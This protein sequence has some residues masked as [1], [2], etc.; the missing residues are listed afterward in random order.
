MTQVIDLANVNFTQEAFDA[1][2][3]FARKASLQIATLG[4]SKSEIP[5]E[6]GRIE[7]D[8]SLTI[9]VEVKSRGLEFSFLVPKGHWVW[10]Q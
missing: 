10:R 5:D 3:A 7:E 1:Y 6:Q 9:F 2:K 8:G 4:V